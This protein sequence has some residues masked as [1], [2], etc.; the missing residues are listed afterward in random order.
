MKQIAGTTAWLLG[1][2][3]FALVAG[4]DRVLAWLPRRWGG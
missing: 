1:E 4:I 3:W 2:L